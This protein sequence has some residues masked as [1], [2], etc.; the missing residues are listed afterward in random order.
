LLT[1]QG[2]WI[3]AVALAVVLGTSAFAGSALAANRYEVSRMDVVPAA[4][5]SPARPLPVRSHFTLG[6]DE[7]D[8]S[9]RPAS[10]KTYVIGTEGV[11]AFPKPFPSCSVAQAKRRR[12]P[13]RACAAAQ[14]GGGQVRAAAGLK[15]DDRMSESFA[16]NLRL[17]LYN[18]GRGV[19]L[20]LDTDPPEPPSFTSKRLGCT[21]SLHTAIAGRFDRV[22]I[23]GRASVDLRFTLPPS[24]LS[25]L[26]G[27]EGALQVVDVKLDARSAR[28]RVAGQ[29]RSVGFFSAIGCKGG[30]RTTRAAFIDGDG[31]RAEAT[32]TERC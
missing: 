15:E 1:E 32:R 17:R 3:A 16:C 25:P 19:A 6:V 30:E 2:R 28:T 21:A 26:P 11:L 31:T 14:V 18:T 9:K 27:W 12:G 7:Q 5:G 13:A 10:I 8:P 23:G 24:L 20:R 29:S 4:G 22:T